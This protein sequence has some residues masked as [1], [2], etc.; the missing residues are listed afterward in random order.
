MAAAAAA[1][2]AVVVAFTV[3]VDVLNEEEE[4]C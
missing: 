2:G 4:G 1:A 3:E